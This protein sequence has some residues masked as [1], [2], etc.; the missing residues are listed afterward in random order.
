MPM[1]FPAIT[2]TQI[3]I[4]ATETLRRMEIMLAINASSIHTAATSQI[5]SAITGSMV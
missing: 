3:S 5:S 1:K 2:P 4:K